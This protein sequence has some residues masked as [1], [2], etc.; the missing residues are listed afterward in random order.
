MAFQLSPGVNVSEVDLTGFIPA[1]ATTGGATVGQ[2]EWGP[3]E[4][5]QVIS[6]K[7]KLEEMFGKPTDTNY[8]DW[9]SAA[10]FLSYSNNLTVIR[11]VDS[12]AKNASAEP[13][14]AGFL[15]KNETDHSNK[16]GS[17]GA[18]TALMVARY[19]GVKGNGLK[20]SIADS[21]TFSDWPL[22]Y[23]QLFD[24]APGTSEFISGVGGSNDE[25]HIVIEDADGKFTGTPGQILETFAYVS[26]ASNAKRLDGEPSFYGSIINKQS[27]Y[28][29]WMKEPTSGFA[30][31][32]EITSATVTNGGSGYTTAPTVSI[33][34][35][36]D[37][38]GATATSTLATT[39]SAKTATINAVG[40]S[41][42]DGESVTISGNGG[43]LT[44]TIAVTAGE[45]DSFTITDAGSDFTGDLTGATVTGGSGS[46][47]TAD[48]TIG[49]A[50]ASVTITAGGSSYADDTEITFTGDGSGAAA[51]PVIFSE[52]ADGAWNT[53]GNNE[54]FK[55]LSSPITY[56]LGGGTDSTDVS[57]SELTAGWDFLKNS[58]VVDV[59]LLIAGD[60]GGESNHTTV[61]KHIADNIADFRKDCMLFFSP[62]SSDVV[63]IE[64]STAAANCVT[65]RETVNINSSYVVMDSGWKYQYDQYNDKYR[66]IPL[67]ADMAGLCAN[68]DNVADPWFSPAGFSRGQVKNSI[69]LALNPSKASRDILYKAGIN[70]VVSFA[71]EGT[72]LYGDR[73][74]LAKPSAFQKINVRRLF[75]VLEKAIATAAKFQLFEFNDSFTRAQFVNMVEPYLREVQGRRGIFEY[76]VVCDDTNNTPEVIDSSEFVADI[77]IKPTYSINFIQLNFVA[78]RTGV[79]FEEI[80]GG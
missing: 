12:N 40:S 18:N 52:D 34:D 8:I 15:V 50:V 66:W 79:E 9:F 77:Y 25:L 62:K 49:Y 48:V 30:T 73:T 31:A 51:D 56:T 24:T 54:Y 29:W 7:K 53:S 2:Y 74:Q 68:T 33:A 75:I 22:K 11:V 17:S 70:P 26:K 57:S 78:V 67:N 63:N 16:L 44:A 3:V 39:G 41:Y 71:G 64:E 1:V 61:V 21:Q 42:V 43:T 20:I 6:D 35:T 23:R 55:A 27:Q 72:L 28:V 80:I 36:G 47:A 76:K 38:S 65:T 58:E 59:S 19:P 45:I 14:P 4:T 13:T 46:G 37:G 10:N 60:A 69:Q 32:G 5:Y